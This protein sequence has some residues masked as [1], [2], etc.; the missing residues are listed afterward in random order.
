MDKEQILVKL[1]NLYKWKNGTD[2]GL[3][4]NG[5]SSKY[6]HMMKKVLK[7]KLEKE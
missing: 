1:I 4:L 7:M 5:S 3:L 6:I 2:F